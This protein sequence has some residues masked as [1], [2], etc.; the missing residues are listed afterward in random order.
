M[1]THTIWGN[2]FKTTVQEEIVLLTACGLIS[3]VKKKDAKAHNL[4]DECGPKL[5]QAQQGIM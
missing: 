3:P 5:A 2:T 1:Q 4:R